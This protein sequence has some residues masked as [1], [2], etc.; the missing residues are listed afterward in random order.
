MI[1]KTKKAL[2]DYTKTLLN[3]YAPQTNLTPKDFDFIR[4][5]VD[6]HPRADQKI[7]IGIQSIS[8]EMSPLNKNYKQFRIHRY[9]SSTTDFSYIRCIDGKISKERLFKMACR[10]AIAPQIQEFRNKHSPQENNGT[11]VDHH[12]PSFDTLVNNFYLSDPF[13]FE[14]LE[15]EG[16]DDNQMT[17]RFIDKDLEQ[18]FADYHRTHANLR[19]ISAHENLTKKRSNQHTSQPSQR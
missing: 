4:D 5:L 16:F 8:V 7:G 15:I 13:P 2:K 9:D 18:R 14:E 3:S 10:T 17:K 6:R 1:F 12:Q 19:L 11:H